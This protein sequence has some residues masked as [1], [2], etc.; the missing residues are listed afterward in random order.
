M[1]A[2]IGRRRRRRG[3]EEDKGG[4]GGGVTYQYRGVIRYIIAVSR[5]SSNAKPLRGPVS[6]WLI[7]LILPYRMTTSRTTDPP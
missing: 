6:S 2:A 5:V 1:V 4:G 7:S 3:E